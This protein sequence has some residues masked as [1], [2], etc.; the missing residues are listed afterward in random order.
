MW[1]EREESECG[2]KDVY[3]LVK[4][5]A[6]GLVNLCKLGSHQGA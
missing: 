2:R 6:S 4:W 3:S 5:D 1:R